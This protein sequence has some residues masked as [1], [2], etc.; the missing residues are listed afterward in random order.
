M[1]HFIG[2][3]MIKAMP[4]TGHTFADHH[5]RFVP[6][7]EEDQPGYM[8]EYEDG[9]QSWSPK[10][11]FE[12]AYLPMG[13]IPTG[14]PNDSKI[15]E[16]M[17]ESFMGIPLCLKVTDKS[18][19]VKVIPRTGFEQF[20]VSSCVDPAN[21]DHEIGKAVATRK[22]KDRIWGY[23]GFVLQWAKYGLHP[24]RQDTPDV[25]PEVGIGPESV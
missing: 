4:M 23:L 19:L 1:Q 12:K 6:D 8:V 18:T 20:E 14:M 24:H 5:D 13:Q 22:I 16:Q 10:D 2:V 21:Y 15:T 7:G 17:V 9:Y 3:K 11:V 25:I